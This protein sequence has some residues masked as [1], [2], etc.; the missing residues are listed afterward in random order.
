MTMSRNV[1]VKREG[2][3][4]ESDNGDGKTEKESSSDGNSDLIEQLKLLKE[5]FEDQRSR[6]RELQEEQIKSLNSL[7]SSIKGLKSNTHTKEVQT[8]VKERGVKDDKEQ[9]KEN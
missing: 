6:D 8:I 3:D 2:S 5:T 1:N 4:Q 7:K 9:H